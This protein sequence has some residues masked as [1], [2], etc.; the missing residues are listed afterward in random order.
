MGKFY[1]HL[2]DYSLLDIN[3]DKVVFV[4]NSMVGLSIL[5][6]GMNLLGLTGVY[7][8]EKNDNAVLRGT[9]KLHS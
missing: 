4:G 8:L 1:Y 3:P 6:P 2:K 5:S 9:R 7:Y